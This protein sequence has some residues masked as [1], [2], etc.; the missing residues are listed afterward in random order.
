VEESL[1]IANEEAGVVAGAGVADVAMD[2]GMGATA[3]RS[4]AWRRQQ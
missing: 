1:K 4:R 2:A 3:D